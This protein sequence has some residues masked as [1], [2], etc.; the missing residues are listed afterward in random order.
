[1][2]PERRK[3]GGKKLKTI[4]KGFPNAEILFCF[5]F[6]SAKNYRSTRFLGLHLTDGCMRR[7]GMLWRRTYQLIRTLPASDAL[8][9][10]LYPLW[11]MTPC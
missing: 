8:D 3:A 10:P 11:R 2:R 1:M 4:V 5:D 7:R 6:K 9:I